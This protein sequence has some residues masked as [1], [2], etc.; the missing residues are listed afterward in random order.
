A[1]QP[2]RW[3]QCREHACGR[4]RSEPSPAAAPGSRHRARAAEARPSVGRPHASC[5]CRLELRDLHVLDAVERQLQEALAQLPEE[6]GVAG[7]EEAIAA[8][9]AG[10][11]LDSLALQGLS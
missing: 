5:G 9:A 2:R 8:L 1:A 10:A 11:V 6:L 7:G 3:T 4:R